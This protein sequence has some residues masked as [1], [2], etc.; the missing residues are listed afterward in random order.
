MTDPKT[1]AEVPYYL[2]A[3]TNLTTT[4]AGQ[5]KFLNLEEG[6]I[7]GVRFLQMM[8]KY[9][10]NIYLTEFDFF[11]NIIANV[12]A[13]KEGRYILLEYKIYQVLI[14]NLDKLNNNKLLN[15]LRMIRNCCFEYEKYENDILFNNAI[16]FNYLLKILYDTN[17]SKLSNFKYDSEFLVNLECICFPNVSIDQASNEREIINDLVIDIFLVLTN[18]VSC[19]EIMK[20]KNTKLIL[21]K[22]VS[23]CLK[24]AEN[25]KDRLFVICNYLE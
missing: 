12:T 20:T 25:F 8:D 24:S 13:L 5:K 4:E 2:M 21:E 7:S 18:S 1:F 17:L 22:L 6:N 10:E 9:F 11:S 23:V 14:G 15:S 19:I 3:L 16:L